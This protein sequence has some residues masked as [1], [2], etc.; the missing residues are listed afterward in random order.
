MAVLR[1]DPWGDTTGSFENLT[2]K[3]AKPVVKA[4]SDAAK[5]VAADVKQQVMGDY[6]PAMEQAQQA[7]HSS[8]YAK[9]SE[10]KQEEAKKKQELMIQTRQNLDQINKKIVEIRQKKAKEAEQAKQAEKKDKDQKKY[11]ERKKN[12]DPFW[13]KMLKGKTGSK[14]GNVRAGG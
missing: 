3:V 13:K 7:G 9:A 12:E 2:Q 5:A 6:G 10:D 4:T 14:E 8:S 1:R 11:E